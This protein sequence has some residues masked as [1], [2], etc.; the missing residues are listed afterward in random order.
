M[1]FNITGG[2]TLNNTVPRDRPNAPVLDMTVVRTTNTVARIMWNHT[3]SVTAPHSGFRVEFREASTNDWV[4]A[5]NVPSTSQNSTQFNFDINNVSDL[6]ASYEFRVFATSTVVGG[7]ARDSLASNVV[8]LTP[9]Q[10]DRIVDLAVDRTQGIDIAQLQWTYPGDATLL[11]AFL[12]EAREGASG[13][14]ATLATVDGAVQP[15][16]TPP[17]YRFDIAGVADEDDTFFYRI[18][19]ITRNDEVSTPS[20]VVSVVP[21][22][23]GAPQSFRAIVNAGV[24]L[25]TSVSLT[26]TPPAEVFTF[27]SGFLLEYRRTSSDNSGTFMQVGSYAPDV[28]EVEFLPPRAGAI[29]VRISTI[30]SNDLTSDPN[31]T[32]P[33]IISTGSATDDSIYNGDGDYMAY[34]DFPITAE[35]I[36]MGQPAGPPVLGLIPGSVQGGTYDAAA[37]TLTGRPGE[38][39]VFDW[40]FTIQQEQV[41]RFRHFYLNLERVG[42]STSPAP[43]RVWDVNTGNVILE[44]ISN[45]SETNRF[46]EG[47]VATRMVYFPADRMAS[48]ANT[49]FD[50]ERNTGATQLPMY[51]SR[52]AISLPMRRVFTFRAPGVITLRVTMLADAAGFPIIPVP[53][54][55][56][57]TTAIS[58]EPFASEIHD[59]RTTSSINIT[60]GSGS[61]PFLF[62]RTFE[63][64]PV[65]VATAQDAYNV[66]VTNASATGFT[67]NAAVMSNVTPAD[68]TSVIVDYIARGY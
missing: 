44:V 36:Y 15:S 29:D 54:T 39:L 9:D 42:S 24:G 66:W 6:S 68:N 16:G 38:N 62:G 58:L 53:V 2:L 49:R 41:D 21:Q 11:R 17:L 27:T 35:N 13:D 18:V 40:N 4:I 59:Q 28:F 67:L 3:A 45:P 22:R 33:L 50:D 5:G 19:A 46:Y 14:F 1:A 60:S 57:A 51:V 55:G 37:G 32:L 23:P 10:P 30:G 52:S 8:T 12:I 48:T 43:T 47:P 7:R 26:W 63:Q 64:T 34:R 61:M 20:N 56:S 25:V 65:I 31:P